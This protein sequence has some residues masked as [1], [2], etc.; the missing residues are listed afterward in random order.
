M[1]IKPGGGL[2]H[3][4]DD[5]ITILLIIATAITI[6]FVALVLCGEKLLPEVWQILLIP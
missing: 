4:K 3:R 5:D 6:L 1:G 2:M